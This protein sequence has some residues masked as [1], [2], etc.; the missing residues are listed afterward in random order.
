ML[1]LSSIRLKGTELISFLQRLGVS[2]N[3]QLAEVGSHLSVNS[4]ALVVIH[5]LV[6]LYSYKMPYSEEM[7]SD[8]YYLMM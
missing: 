8:G 5:S 7:E 1:K 6:S 2:G 4:L 3:Y